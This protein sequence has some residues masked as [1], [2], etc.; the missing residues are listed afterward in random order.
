MIQQMVIL[1][2]IDRLLTSCEGKT[3]RDIL[4]IPTNLR[5]IQW[6]SKKTHHFAFLISKK[7]PMLIQWFCIYL[8]FRT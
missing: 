1:D 6:L 2:K 3:V 5:N 7:I 4:R 8:K